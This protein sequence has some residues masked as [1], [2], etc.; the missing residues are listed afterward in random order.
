MKERIKNIVE[1]PISSLKGIF[2]ALLSSAITV[3]YHVISVGGDKAVEQFAKTGSLDWKSY[4]IPVAG[5]VSVFLASGGLQ[6]DLKPVEKELEASPLSPVIGN[7]ASKVAQAGISLMITKVEEKLGKDQ[8][9]L[10]KA[11]VDV[12]TAHKEPETELACAEIQP[13]LTGLRG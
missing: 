7:V 6:K 11:L 8:P 12:L 1:S 9:A 2:I 4:V 5:A 3:G 13:E 10:T